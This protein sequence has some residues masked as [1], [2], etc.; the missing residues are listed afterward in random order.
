MREGGQ[1]SIFNYLGRG[2]RGL[3]SSSRFSAER[4]LQKGHLF[5]S[6]D[7][8]SSNTGMSYQYYHL[9]RNI[10]QEAS[11]RDIFIWHKTSGKKHQQGVRTLLSQLLLRIEWSQLAH[12]NLIVQ[13]AVWWEVL[14]YH[15]HSAG[16][17]PAAVMA[18]ILV[19]RNSD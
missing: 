4:L 18:T 1:Y 8:K 5:A 7:A 13:H 12:I 6:G 17:L 19:W 9:A 10:W 11:G 15:N 3:V 14:Q 16:Q 2:G